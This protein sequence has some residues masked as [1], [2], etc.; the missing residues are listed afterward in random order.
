VGLWDT[1]TGRSRPKRANLDALFL[2][3]SAAITLQTA[4]GLT[5]TGDGSVCYRAATGAGFHETQDEVVALLEGSADA[6]VV[7]TSSDE[8]GFRWLQVHRDPDRIQL[9]RDQRS[10]DC[11]RLPGGGRSRDIAGIGR[12]RRQR[13]QSRRDLRSAP[14]HGADGAAAE[15]RRGDDGSECTQQLH[16]RF[17]GL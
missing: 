2:V 4:A 6:P 9:V 16:W 15:E 10:I 1:L 13:L 8:F 14:Q 11:D 7:Q 3:P 5:A 17:P 12:F